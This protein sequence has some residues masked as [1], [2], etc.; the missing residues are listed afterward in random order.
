MSPNKPLCHEETLRLITLAQQ[1]DE[2]AKE[3]ITESN[4][5][6]VK[7]IVKRY[8]GRGVE[9]EDLFQ[10]GSVGLIKAILRFNVSFELRFSTYAV[11]MIAG[12][13]KRFLRDDGMVKVS[14]SVKE[15]QSRSAAA[16]AALY[17]QTGREPGVA[18]IAETLN[19][20]PE[21][22]AAALSAARPTVSLNEAVS[23]DEGAG[24][25]MDFACAD[26]SEEE[27]VDRLLIRDLLSHL[28]ERE[29]RIVIERFYFDRTQSDI[30]EGLGIS[31]VQVSR[32]LSR[33]LQKMRETA[34]SPPASGACRRE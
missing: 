12:E 18:E 5:A 2:A 14:R 4:L 22:V 8:L 17:E 7:S 19:Q 3:R 1:G 6:L 29:R 30:A 16:A 26:E 13:I 9:Y 15:L 28:S 32:L 31:Q 11:P 25:L 33:I 23:S 24:T 20:R 34:E 21:D 10:L 27:K